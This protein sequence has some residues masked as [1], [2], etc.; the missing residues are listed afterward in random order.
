MRLR[1][2]PHLVSVSTVL[3]L[4][5]EIAVG[6]RGGGTHPR[7]HRVE[8]RDGGGGTRVA[9]VRAGEN[10]RRNRGR[11]RR[12]S[13]SSDHTKVCAARRLKLERCF[14]SLSSPES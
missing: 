9:V 14:K 1:R 5:H 10:R 2:R 11:R 13:E 8:T 6:A 12:V 4:V 3:G 7:G